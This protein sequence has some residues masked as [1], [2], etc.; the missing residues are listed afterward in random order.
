MATSKRSTPTE[1]TA[2]YLKGAASNLEDLASK[3]STVAVQM[4]NEGFDPLAIL[5]HASLTWGMEK[6][7]TFTEACEKAIRAR[8]MPDPSVPD[9]AVKKKPKKGKAS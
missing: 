1:L 2:A 8:R 4:E 7:E 9:S 3:I 5:H 6:L